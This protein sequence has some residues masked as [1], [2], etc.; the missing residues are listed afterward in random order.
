MMWKTSREKEI[1]GKLNCVK[2]V[3]GFECA[4]VKVGQKCQCIGAAKPW[5]VVRGENCFAFM[6]SGFALLIRNSLYGGFFF[7]II[8]INCPQ[9]VIS[10]EKTK[11]SEFQR[12]H[13]VWTEI[14]LC[15]TFINMNRVTRWKVLVFSWFC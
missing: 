12:K 9:S 14:M 2:I 3:K 6:R 8:W 4:H 11:R 15:E 5:S 13:H 1:A 7:S 10:V